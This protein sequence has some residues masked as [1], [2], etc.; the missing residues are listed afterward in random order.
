MAY[1]MTEKGHVGFITRQSISVFFYVM[2]RS[3]NLGMHVKF[4][5]FGWFLRKILF[6]IWT[7][8]LI[9]KNIRFRTSYLISYYYFDFDYWS[10]WVSIVNLML[11]NFY[12]LSANVLYLGKNCVILHVHSSQYFFKHLI[13]GIFSIIFVECSSSIDFQNNL[14]TKKLKNKKLCPKHLLKF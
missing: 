8:F 14:I 10:G 2:F 13:N 5:S 4:F 9:V 6:L 11:V 12:D 3:L 1:K 7:K